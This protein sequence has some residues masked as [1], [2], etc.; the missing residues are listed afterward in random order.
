MTVNWF[1]LSKTATDPQTID[2]GM[3][4]KIGDHNNDPD[5]HM[6]VGET[7]DL[8]RTNDVIDHP[9]ESVV[10]DKIEISARAFVAIVDPASDENF[11]TIEGAITYAIGVG[12]GSIYVVAGTHYLSTAIELPLNIYIVGDS[13]LTTIIS[14]GYT[15]GEYFSIDWTSGDPLGI[16]G[17][18]N[19]VFDNLA[20]GVIFDTKY[21]GN[22]GNTLRFIN[23]LNLNNQLLVGRSLE[24]LRFVDCVFSVGTVRLISSQR[25]CDVLRTIFTTSNYAALNKIFTNSNGLAESS[26]YDIQDSE[27]YLSEEYDNDIFD[28]MPVNKSQIINCTFE[29]ANF[30]TVSFATTKILY[31]TITLDADGYLG[32]LRDNNIIIGNKLTGSFVNQI[33]L[34]STADRNIIMGNDITR[35]LTVGG[36]DNIIVNNT[37][38]QYLTTTTVLTALDFANNAVVY[39]AP[40]ATKTLTT[41]VPPAGTQRALILYQSNTTAKTITFG[42]GFKTTGNLAM[43][44]TANRRFTFIF[45]SDGT[46]LIQIARSTAIA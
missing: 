42:S 22:S 16:W 35:I 11:D 27:F 26:Q 43:G 15:S 45:V 38:P 18:E 12:G 36:D 2:E 32:I 37:L 17:F 34:T 8:H 31:N 20:G 33:Q 41:E 24:K 14:A 29:F 6:L 5:A 25:G 23:C 28:S 7:L 10:N 19:I 1:G 30:D 13:A 46:S 3:D 40:S 4:V 44:T 21:T 39:Q 9:A